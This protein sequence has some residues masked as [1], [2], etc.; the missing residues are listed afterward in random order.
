MF[1]KG[2][3]FPTLIIKNNLAQVNRCPEKYSKHTC[4]ALKVKPGEENQSLPEQNL[5]FH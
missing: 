5:K 3:Y 1:D 4:N 2:P